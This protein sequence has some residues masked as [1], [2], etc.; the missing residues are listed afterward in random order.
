M[1]LTK[2]LK[3]APTP[4]A[5]KQEL[6]EDIHKFCRRLRLVEFF[7]DK[8]SVV[9]ESL[10]RNKSNFTPPKGRNSHLDQYIDTLSKFP[11][12]KWTRIITWFYFRITKVSTYISYES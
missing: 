10:I 11:L 3:F 6:E 5:N 2:G 4:T 12:N 9:D 1:N 7:I 8:D